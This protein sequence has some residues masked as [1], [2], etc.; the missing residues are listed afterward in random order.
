MDQF[1]PSESIIGIIG[2]IMNLTDINVEWVI[3]VD[4]SVVCL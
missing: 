3:F 2:V 1:K 4:I